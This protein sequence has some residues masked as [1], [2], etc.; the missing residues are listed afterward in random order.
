MTTIQLNIPSELAEKL[1]PYR[2]HLE[3]LLELGLQ[4]FLEHEQQER[5]TRRDQLLQAIASS[6]KVKLPQ[7]YPD[8]PPYRRHTP[9]DI[10]GKAVSEIVIE[11][12]GPLL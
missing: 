9:I 3:E 6:N 10:A 5:Q 4:K 7:S 1:E 12:R 2:D 8:S 11:Q